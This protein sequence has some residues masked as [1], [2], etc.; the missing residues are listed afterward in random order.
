MNLLIYT[1][2][3]EL[4]RTMQEFIDYY[5][6]RRYHEAIGNVTPAVSARSRSEGVLRLTVNQFPNW[7]ISRSFPRRCMPVFTDT[8]L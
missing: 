4:R 1:S 2:P 7:E 6:H 8:L 3:E 5:N